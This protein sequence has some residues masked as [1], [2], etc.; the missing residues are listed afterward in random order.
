MSIDARV[1]GI[2]KTQSDACVKLTLE[3][4][5]G[6]GPA[7]HDTL[8]ILNSDTLRRTRKWARRL[9]GLIG[10]DV[11]G[12]SNDMVGSDLMLGQT[13]LAIQT[14]LRHGSPSIGIYLVDNWAEVIAYEI[15]T[16]TKAK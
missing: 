1:V 7:R 15:A 6:A 9:Q 10:L 16:Q 8:R 13:R 5:P 11:W 14:S 3:P 12:G 4:R 2:R